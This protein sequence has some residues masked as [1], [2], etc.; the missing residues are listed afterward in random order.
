VL[1]F[2]H[3]VTGEKVRCESAPPDDFV[4]ALAALRGPGG[5]ARS[6]GDPAD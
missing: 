6:A 3:P 1:G 5:V 4:R 2:V